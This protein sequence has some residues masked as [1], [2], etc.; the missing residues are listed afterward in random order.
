M[1]YQVLRA[2]WVRPEKGEATAAAH[3]APT[4]MHRSAF[5]NGPIQTV[6]STIS[7]NIFFIFCLL[8]SLPQFL[9]LVTPA[10][11]Q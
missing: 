5:E 1:Q 11:K 7:R 4:R 6:F 9:R 3:A 2:G 10:E 8:I